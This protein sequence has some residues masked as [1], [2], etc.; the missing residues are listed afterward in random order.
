LV[1]GITSNAGAWTRVASALALWGY[2]VVAP[3]LR[4]HGQSPK[5]ATGYGHEALAADLARSVDPAPDVLVGHSLGGLLAVLATAAGQL[6]PRRVVLEDPAIAVD[7]ALAREFAQRWADLRATP[8]EARAAKTRLESPRWTEDDVQERLHALDELSWEAVDQIW[9]DPWDAW[10]QALNLSVPVLWILADPSPFVPERDAA[11][12]RERYGPDAVR[13]V[14]GAGHSVHR[15]DC[16]AFLRLLQA[17]LA[18]VPAK[19][20]A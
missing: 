3:D 13:V 4:G 17:W 14:R 20:G 6:R 8:R 2:R 7:G 5:P 9:T 19:R 10:S 16:D 18:G 15:D 1:H 11:R 12:L